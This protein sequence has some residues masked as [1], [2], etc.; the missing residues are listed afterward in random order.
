MRVPG[1]STPITPGSTRKVSKMFNDPSFNELLKK[2]NE[3]ANY[4]D[5]YLERHTRVLI[6]I[7]SKRIIA[8]ILTHGDMG[9]MFTVIAVNI[10]LI[11]Q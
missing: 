5:Y 10:H 2:G 9:T 7:T 4:A 6:Y 1:V 11:I 3:R 8:A